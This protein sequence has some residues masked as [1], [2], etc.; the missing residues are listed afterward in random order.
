MATQDT[1]I[2]VLEKAYESLEKRMDSIED[3]L[4]D[5]KMEIANNN[6]TMIKVIVA[7]SGTVVGAVLST[8]VVVLTQLI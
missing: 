8:L 3:K 7:S 2:T 1:R 5:M 4:D 6:H